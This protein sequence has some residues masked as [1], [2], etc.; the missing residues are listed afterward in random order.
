M[1]K[2]PLSMGFPRQEYWSVLPFPTP[3]GLPDPGIEPHL[4]H[5]QV[6]CLPLKHLGSP[7]VLVDVCKYREKL[8][9]APRRRMTV[10]T[11][12]EGR[13][14]GRVHVIGLVLHCLVYSLY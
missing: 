5:W 9:K 3:G 12:G 11:S 13:R 14:L 4:L 10:L 8:W 2:A 6:D 1:M 7:E